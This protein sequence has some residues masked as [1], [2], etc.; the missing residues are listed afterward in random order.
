[1]EPVHG[2][3]V[4]LDA[5]GQADAAAFPLELLARQP[6]GASLL[7]AAYTLLIGA[8]ILLLLPAALLPALSRVSRPKS[9]EKG[10]GSPPQ[11]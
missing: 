1:M 5:C 3:V 6:C 2:R 11:P 7:F 4:R 10:E 8:G 9:A